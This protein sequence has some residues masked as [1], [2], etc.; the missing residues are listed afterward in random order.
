[1][2]LY[3]KEVD[4][5]VFWIGFA[6]LQIVTWLSTDGTIPEVRSVM[7]NRWIGVELVDAEGHVLAHSTRRRW[8]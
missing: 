5:G 1:M 8:R 6:N 2:E 4:G 3:P 7:T